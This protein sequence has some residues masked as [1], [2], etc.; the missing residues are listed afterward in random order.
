MQDLDE[1]FD[2]EE[3]WEIIQGFS[4][5][6]VS[7]HGRI[8]IVGHDQIRRINVNQRGMPMTFLIDD[9]G[10]RHTK[11]LPRL[12]AEH[13]IPQPDERF[14]TPINLNGDRSNCHVA[15]LLWRPRPFAIRFNRQY[16]WDIFHGDETRLLLLDT[17]EEFESVRQPVR[18]FGLVCT[19]VWANARTRSPVWP[20]QQ[21]YAL[22]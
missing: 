19:D 21:R 1:M 5:Y 7:T 14:D 22:L 8:K 16:N 6:A 4:R 18:R 17:E 11:L 9:H 13:F 15:N 2:V 20:T 3:R 10:V 12:V